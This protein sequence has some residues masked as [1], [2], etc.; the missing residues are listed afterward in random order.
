GAIAGRGGVA[1]LPNEVGKRGIFPDLQADPEQGEVVQP[2]RGAAAPG[3]RV[4][5]AGG[6]VAVEPG[7]LCAGGAGGEGHQGQP[8]SGAAGSSSRNPR[9][10]QEAGAPE[11]PGANWPS[12]AGGPATSKRQDEAPV[13]KSRRSQATDAP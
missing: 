5:A 13:A 4:L 9:S 12:R 2:G 10:P 1:I 6:A 3:N 7:G 8:A 11:L